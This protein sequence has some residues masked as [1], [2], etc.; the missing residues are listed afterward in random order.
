MATAKKGTAVSIPFPRGK[1]KKMKGQAE[2][3]GRR[4]KGD[5]KGCAAAS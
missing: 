3:R 2:Q 5:A 1:E 4:G